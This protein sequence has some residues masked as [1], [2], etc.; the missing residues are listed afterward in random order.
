MY[1]YYIS[2]KFVTSRLKAPK[3]AEFSGYRDATVTYLGNCRHRISAYVDSQN[4]FGAMLRSKYIATVKYTGED[5]N[6]NS[7]YVLE[8]ISINNR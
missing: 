2:E 3:T 4:G 6:R 5:E 8:D 7:N 1:A